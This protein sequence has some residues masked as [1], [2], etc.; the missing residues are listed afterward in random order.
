VQDF[1]VGFALVGFI[2]VFL[3]WFRKS[4]VSFRKGSQREKSLLSSRVWGA[5]KSPKING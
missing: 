5:F 2:V 3:V 1:Q 4:F